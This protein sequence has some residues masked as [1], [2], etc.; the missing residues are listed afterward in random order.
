MYYNFYFVV[1]YLTFCAEYIT[2]KTVPTCKLL[3]SFGINFQ[4]M[5]Y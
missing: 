3:G 2:V 5:V 1:K 4:S